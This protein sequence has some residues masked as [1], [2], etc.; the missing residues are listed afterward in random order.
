MS[1]LK[2]KTIT[3]NPHSSTVRMRECSVIFVSQEPLR[4]RQRDY[5]SIRA[6]VPI[7]LPVHRIRSELTPVERALGL[8]HPLHYG[9]YQRYH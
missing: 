9:R 3:G 1:H 7:H 2:K 4:P 8:N 5:P 6:Q